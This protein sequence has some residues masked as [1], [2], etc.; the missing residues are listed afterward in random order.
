MQSTMTIREQIIERIKRDGVNVDY[1]YL[2]RA[3]DDEDVEAY[4]KWL[5]GLSDE[6]LLDAYA[7]VV[8]FPGD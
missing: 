7:R 6:G 3:G 1:V 4:A 8:T 5:G 2:G